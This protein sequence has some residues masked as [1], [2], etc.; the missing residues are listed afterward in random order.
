MPSY[1][2]C[3]K[4]EL[5]GDNQAKEFSAGEVMVCVANVSGEYSAMNN[6][7]A[8]RGGPLGQGPVMEGKV[9]CPLHG[10]MYDPKTGIPEDDPHRRVAVYPLRVEGEDVFVE[11]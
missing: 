3:A 1:R 2:I 8:H 9:I 7:C 6:F 4:S 5:P 11:V 10:W